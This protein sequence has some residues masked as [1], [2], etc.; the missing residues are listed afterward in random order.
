MQAQCQSC[1]GTCSALMCRVRDA[2]MLWDAC[3][4]REATGGPAC[5]VGRDAQGVKQVFADECAYQAGH[6]RQ[7]GGEFRYAAYLF[8]NTHCDWVL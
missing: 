2:P 4:Q 8:G 7:H 3:A 5:R 6:H 1:I